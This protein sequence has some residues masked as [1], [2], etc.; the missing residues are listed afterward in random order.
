[1]IKRVLFRD[2]DVSVLN[3]NKVLDEA[4]RK[5]T[6][7][8]LKVVYWSKD[9]YLLFYEGK[10]YKALSFSPDG[11]RRVHPPEEFRIESKEGVAS[12][13]ET[14]I[15]DLVGIIEYRHDVEKDGALVFFPFGTPIQEPVSV[16]FLDI[17]K[18]FLLAQRSHLDGYVALFTE[19]SLFGIVVFQGG[20][21]VAVF[22][23]DGSFRD[24]AVNYINANLI[25]AKSFMSMYTLEP[26]VLSFFYSLHSDNVRRI[27][28]GFKTYKEAQEA[29]SKDKRDAIVVVEGEGIHRYDLFFKGYLVE[30][31]IKDRGIFVE[32]L[33]EK[34]KLS[35]KVENLPGRSI[36]LYDVSLIEKP[37]PLE[38]V[39][40]G[41]EVE[42]NSAVEEVRT[43]P[44]DKVSEIKSAFIKGIGPL[45]KL[46]WE[47]RLEELRFKESAM[48]ESQLKILIEKL[49]REI[50]EESAARDF[51]DKVRNILP[52]I[53]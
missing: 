44:I 22:G 14:T 53:I 25:P 17:N 15:D 46:L 4:R 6:T 42:E 30:S 35:R 11:I 10:P 51:L 26:E 13:F 36:R 40:H 1:M 8:F 12:F 49:K 48:T 9:D 31:L 18:E 50:P 19:E 7:G 45:G 16:S 29:V 21:P 2:L 33:Q 27:E 37:Q 20:F 38:I 23:G 24:R 28:E 43:I 3:L 39:L 47:K 52:D 34:E 41:V 5:D 32:D